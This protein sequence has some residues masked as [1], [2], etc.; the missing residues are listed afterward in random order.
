MTAYN[1]WVLG[2]YTHI[3]KFHAMKSRIDKA[4]AQKFISLEKHHQTENLT[5]GELM[6][7]QLEGLNWIYHQWHSMRNGILADEMGLGKTI[8]VIAFLAM[9][10]QD[11]NCFPFLVVV[12]NST[13]P[14]W[15]REIK[16]W[17]PSLRVVSY[18]WS[19]GARQMAYD[20]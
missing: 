10:V 9:M 13:C 11:H 8:Q 12:P 7:Y 5:G 18:Y 20:Y 15:R 19:S 14:N 4:R 16:Q 6:K 3:P 1:D 17:A 2:R